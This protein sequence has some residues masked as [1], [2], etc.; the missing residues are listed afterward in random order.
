[1]P[2]LFWVRRVG[3]QLELIPVSLGSQSSER[4]TGVNPRRS[5]RD[6]SRHHRAEGG[7]FEPPEACTSRL[8]KCDPGGPH[9]PSRSADLHVFGDES[10]RWEPVGPNA[11]EFMAWIMARNPQ[12]TANIEALLDHVPLSGGS[13]PAEWCHLV[14]E[15]P[16][17]CGQPGRKEVAHDLDHCPSAERPLCPVLP[18]RSPPIASARALRS[19]G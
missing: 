17:R 9:G 2:E 3:T 5:V 7:G 18:Q 14:T 4:E 12:Q 13:R 6:V 8:F 15:Q 10:R 11:P 19:L 1:M 16:Q